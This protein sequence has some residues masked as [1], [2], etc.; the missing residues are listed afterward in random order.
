MGK[1]NFD[2]SCESLDV[3][4]NYSR[5]ISV[6]V[7]GA[8]A[9]DVIDAIGL[10]NLIDNHL[11]IDDVLDAVGETAAKQWLEQRGF[12]VTEDA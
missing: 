12:T 9:V 3:S 10:S 7:T 6:S 8:S 2:F 5:E 1:V 11:D 4:G